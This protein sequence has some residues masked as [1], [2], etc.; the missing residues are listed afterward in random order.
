MKRDLYLRTSD[1][2]ETDLI[3][4]DEEGII[5]WF[6]TSSITEDGWQ[7]VPVSWVKT[8]QPLKYLTAE[9][10]IEAKLGNDNV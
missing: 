7:S 10:H 9:L 5:S 8:A 3:E 4:Y 2:S 6:V 1:G